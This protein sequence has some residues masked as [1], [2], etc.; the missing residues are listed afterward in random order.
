MSMKKSLSI[1]LFVLLTMGLNSQTITLPMVSQKAMVSQQVGLSK[2]K[3]IYHSPAVNNRTVWGSLVP[4]DQV[5]RA[6][7]NDNTIIYFSDDVKVEG[8]D[9]KAGAYGLYMTPHE[10]SVEVHFSSSTS[11]WGSIPPTEEEVV[12]T[13]NVTPETAPHREWLSYDFTDR[14]GNSV[15]AVLNWEKWSI[16]FNIEV[17]VEKVVLEHIRA[18][19]KGLAGFGYLGREQAARYC[20]TNDVALDEAMTW[21]DGSIQ[22]EKRF[23]NLIVKAGLL[24]KAGKNEEAQSARTS[25][26]AL[27]NPAQ[28]NVYGY[29]LMNGGKVDEAIK[30]FLGNIESTPKTH[31]F[32]WGFVDSVGEAY[33]KKGD[34]KNAVKYYTK[35]KEY[36]PDNRQAYLD[37][38]IKG[39][40]EK[41]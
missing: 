32:Y 39:I 10:N 33:L 3:I 37:G 8:Q 24:E 25:A 18:E 31:S 16:P 26:L 1:V 4:Y 11:N 38:V 34:L 13:V 7:A 15:T 28:I 5:W 12:L 21:I 17:D 36:A 27:A 29:Q 2:I 40:K 30:V 41:M 6:G 14:G 9:L 35:A 20:L 23:S 22:A 19:L